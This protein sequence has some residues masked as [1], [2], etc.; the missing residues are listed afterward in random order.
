MP[1]LQFMRTQS[2]WSK[3]EARQ[4]LQEPD[5]LRPALCRRRSHGVLGFHAAAAIL[6]ATVSRVRRS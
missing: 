4:A 5:S 2:D 6:Q 1:A 3:P